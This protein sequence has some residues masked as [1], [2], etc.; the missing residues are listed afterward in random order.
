MPLKN[1]KDIVASLKR[2]EGYLE[3]VEK[4]AIKRKALEEM[5]LLLSV[6]DKERK[7]PK[8]GKRGC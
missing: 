6:F 3:H 5:E 8:G 2:L 4:P 7:R 1:R